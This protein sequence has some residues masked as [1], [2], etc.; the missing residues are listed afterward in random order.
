MEKNL[1]IDFVS[2][3]SCPWCAIG[4]ASLQQALARVNGAISAQITFQPF[5]LN[6]NMVPEGEETTEH[7]AKKY[8]STPEQAAAIKETIRARGAELGFGEVFTLHAFVFAAAEVVLFIREG[9][10]RGARS[11]SDA[12]IARTF[13]F[14]SGGHAI[15]ELFHAVVILAF[16]IAEKAFSL[17]EALTHAFALTAFV[18]QRLAELIELQ[19]KRVE[20]LET[21]SFDALRVA[22]TQANHTTLHHKP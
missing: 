4:L 7:L 20:K 12:A 13:A 15:A 19:T 18:F 11:A 10:R 1:T 3:V 2:D 14:G 21:L 8:G 16:T 17:T 22:A 6:P 9:E 5:E